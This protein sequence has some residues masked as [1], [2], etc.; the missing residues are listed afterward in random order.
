MGLKAV[1]F[2][3]SEVT[4]DI[5]RD[6]KRYI[7][8]YRNGPKGTPKDLFTI[9]PPVI[10]PYREKD[11]GTRI[12]FRYD[13]S[14]FDADA[15]LDG[16]RIKRKCYNLSRLVPGFA[17]T[18]ADERS[19]ERETFISKKGIADFVTEM[20]DGESPLFREIISVDVTR[21]VTDANGAPIGIR[22]EVA[23]QPAASETTYLQMPVR[24]DRDRIHGG[25]LAPPSTG[26]AASTA[27]LAAGLAALFQ[28][29]EVTL[30][31]LVVEVPDNKDSHQQ[32]VVTMKVVKVVMESKY[33]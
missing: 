7:Q 1:T 21:S 6:G 33:Q 10:T 5:R 11:T 14:I 19:R 4:V 28:E 29:V 16:T 2:T 27:E 32:V 8:T 9:E 23:F 18:F 15:E 20:N 30:V 31:V 26:T 17:I 25:V 12:T 22:I 3:S 13:E 24:C